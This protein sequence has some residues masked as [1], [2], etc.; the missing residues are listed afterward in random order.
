M[1]LSF[2]HKVP[3]HQGSFPRNIF[4]APSRLLYR[5]ICLTSGVRSDEMYGCDRLTI[6]LPLPPPAARQ[7]TLQHLLYPSSGVPSKFLAADGASRLPLRVDDFDPPRA[8]PSPW[9]QYRLL[10]YLLGAVAAVTRQ[11]R[12]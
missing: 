2:V 7:R 3:T 5:I 10:L 4:P 11:L 1:S 12:R 8:Q 9:Q 6:L